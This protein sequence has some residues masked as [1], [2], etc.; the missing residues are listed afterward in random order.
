M[1]TE[2]QVQQSFRKILAVPEISADDLDRAEQLLEKI[3]PESPLRHRL[4]EE[5]DQIRQLA[6]VK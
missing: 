5:L 1:L 6:E 3:R 4:S 2:A